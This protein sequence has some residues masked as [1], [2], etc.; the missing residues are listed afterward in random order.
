MFIFQQV[1]DDV[2]EIN[3]RLADEILRRASTEPSAKASNADAWQSAADFFGRGDAD[4]TFLVERVTAAMRQMNRLSGITTEDF[5]VILEGWSVVNRAGHHH[6]HHIHHSSVWSGVYYVRTPAES[7]SAA[8]RDGA[9]E[10]IDPRHAA[11]VT[12]RSI[13]TIRPVS[14][15]LL[16]FPSWLEHWVHP[17]YEAGERI[18]I[19][20]NI[21]LM[22]RMT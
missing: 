3:A 10:F 18:S 6:N 17:H 12:A 5:E 2:A 8:S 22:P 14:G 15:S 4:K 13:R 20:F 16:L 9:I 7:A 11:P 19:P 1:L 21:Y